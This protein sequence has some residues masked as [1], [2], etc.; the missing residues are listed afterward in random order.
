[1]RETWIPLFQDIRNSSMWAHDSDTRI[2]WFTLLTLADPEGYVPAAI[3]GIAIAANVPIAKVREAI[4]LFEAPDPDSRSEAH[5]GRRLQKVERGWLILNFAE[6][7]KR[8]Q[9]EADK[10]RKRR[11]ARAQRA[12]IAD[13]DNDTP[14]D[15]AFLDGFVEGVDA[16]VDAPWTVRSET[17]DAS[18]SKSKS[19]SKSGEG[20][21]SPPPPFGSKARAASGGPCPCGDQERPGHPVGWCDSRSALGTVLLPRDG[22]QPLQGS[23]AVWFTLEGWEPS[24]ELK[25]EAVIAGVPGEVFDARIAELRA[26]PIGGRRGVLDRDAYVRNQFGKWRT[27]HEQSRAVDQRGRTRGDAV[28]EPAGARHTGWGKH[29]PFEVQAFCEKHHLDAAREV[30]D[31]LATGAADNITHREADKAFRKYLQ[32]RARRKAE[33]VP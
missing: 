30:R 17:V 21:G 33:A 28:P 12:A 4:A 29:P 16:A 32:G 9:Q 24:P 1:M 31:F 11:W 23:P 10:A 26:G 25:G 2:V 13:P 6:H 22:L 8:A 19:K 5:E 3:P 15:A 14:E 18:K 20:S 27:W 7:R